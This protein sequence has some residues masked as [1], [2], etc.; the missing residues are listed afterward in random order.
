MEKFLK[1]LE[2]PLRKKS[3][4]DNDSFFTSSSRNSSHSVL[5]LLTPSRFKSCNTNRLLYFQ[6][7][8]SVAAWQLDPSNPSFKLDYQFGAVL[9]KRI[10]PFCDN[11][12]SSKT[13]KFL[14]SYVF[15]PSY[16]YVHLS[17]EVATRVEPLIHRLNVL[18][19]NSLPVPV[20]QPEIGSFWVIKEVG[21]NVWS[22][23]E[24]TDV[25]YEQQT[26]SVFFVDWGDMEIVDICELR[27][28]VKELLDIPCLAFCCRLGGIYPYS[29]SMVSWFF[30]WYLIYYRSNSLNFRSARIGPKRRLR[31]LSHFATP[32]Q[33]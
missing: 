17:E 10:S 27:P 13:I 4:G 14:F 3:T 33:K 23:V 21:R 11:N 31:N 28:L 7:V 8:C 30:K 9:K 16:F 2:M 24:V 5:N 29:K 20:T 12:S 25:N 15:S 32:T 1:S 18:Y 19:E 26:V 6:S 22:R